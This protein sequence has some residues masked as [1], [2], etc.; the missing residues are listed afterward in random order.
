[1]KSIIKLFRRL[2]GLEFYTSPLDEFLAKYEQ[3]HPGLSHSQRKEIDKYARIS[4]LRDDVVSEAKPE[5]FW[6]KF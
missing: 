5:I 1:M 3:G 2:M 6:D 4:K